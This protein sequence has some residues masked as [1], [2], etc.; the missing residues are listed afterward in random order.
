MTIEAILLDLDGTIVNTDHLHYQVWQDI[1]QDYGIEMDKT[2]YRGHIS[3]R[4][5]SAIVEDI[6]PQLTKTAGEKLAEDKEARFRELALSLKPLAGLLDMLSWIDTHKLQ[7]AAVTNAPRA[8]AKFMLE[9]LELTDS[10]DIVVLGDEAIAA[11]PD[12]APYNLALSRL[13][14]SPQEAIAFEDS[15]SG[16]IA[17]VAAGIYSIGITS[18]HSRE[19]LLAVGAKMAIADFAAPQLWQLLDSTVRDRARMAI[20]GKH[21]ADDRHQEL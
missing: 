14:V 12:P 7:T 3:G 9:V 8:N 16:M 2:F 18:T 21:R 20:G 17:A 10:F 5:N 13:G 1:L 6:L 19:V 15:P 4:Q 11:K